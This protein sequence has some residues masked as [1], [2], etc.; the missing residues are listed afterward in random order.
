MATETTNFDVI[1]IGGGPGGY[2]AAD[3]LASCG[4]RVLLIEKAQLGGVCLNMGCIPTKTLL[5][6]AKFFAQIG[7]AA[8]YGLH[9]D[10]LHADLAAIIARKDRV[11]AQLRDGIAYQMSRRAVTVVGG[12]ATC[13]DLHTVRVHDAV[14]RGE[15]IIIATGASPIMPPL[16][17]IDQPHVMTT[18]QM[19]A[20]ESLPHEL[21]ILGGTEI[22]LGFAAIYALLG[23]SVTLV[24]EARELLPHIEQD[25]LALMRLELPSIRFKLGTRVSAI[26][27]D[28]L[29][30]ENGD[31][32]F[33][34]AA[35]CVL[36]CGGRQPNISGMNLEAL[37]LDLSGGRIRVDDSLRTNVPNIYAIGDV[38]GRSMWAHAAMRMAEVATN[39]ILGS[40][41][42]MRWTQIPTVIYT[43]PEIASVGFTEAAAK[44]QGY[45][46]K[47]A[48]LPLNASGRF[49]AENDGR[50]GLCKVVVEAHSG[51][52]L[53]AHMIAPNASEVI[54]GLAA[55]LADEFRV[56]DIQQVLFAHPTVSEIFKDT[57]YELS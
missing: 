25:L 17:G 31:G 53:G 24:S 19:L 51:V 37:N 52:L 50:R 6:S 8:K 7:Q 13:I 45:T 11:I 12:T 27:A 41:D 1:I 46:V 23:V 21:V 57:L 35:D 48:R 42:Q 30:C 47:T 54:F 34:L 29:R 10:N 3:R 14:F 15:K 33:T 5:H 26:H 44:A 32:S 28:H 39:H 49:L 9:V 40:P 20:A 55:M 43:Y 2:T 22:A 18:T 38:T 4:K 16:A 56:Q 36:I